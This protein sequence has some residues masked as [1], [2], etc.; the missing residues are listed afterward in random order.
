MLLMMK[1]LLLLPP[2]ALMK[3]AGDVTRTAF[4]V[5]R[6]RRRRRAARIDPRGQ[7]MRNGRGTVHTHTDVLL[8]LAA[9]VSIRPTL[10][11]HTICASQVSLDASGATTLSA[12]DAP[13][14]QRLCS[15][16]F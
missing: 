16:P 9:L 5:R 2:P 12:T 7:R 11:G 3:V 13:K 8:S 10:C 4:H 1:L 6:M 14:Q 15:S